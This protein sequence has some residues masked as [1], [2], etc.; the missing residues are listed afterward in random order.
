MKY[1]AGIGSRRT[2]P[3]ILI[4]M[5]LIASELQNEFILRSGGAPGADMAFE[6]GVTN[7]NKEIYLPWRGFNDNKSSIFGCDEKAISIANKFHLI[8]LKNTKQSIQSLHGR[9]VY[10]ILGRDLYTPVNFCLCWTPDF[11]ESHSTRTQNTGGTGT[12]ISIASHFGIP[13]INM[14]RKDWMKRFLQLI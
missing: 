11:C 14:S 8:E 12:A 9:N 7:N 10:Q 1:Y 3:K 5:T 2:P 6:N 13:I 4:Q